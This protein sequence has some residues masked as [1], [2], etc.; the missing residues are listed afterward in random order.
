[1]GVLNV[2]PDSFFDGGRYLDAPVAVARGRELVAQGADL[3]DVGGESTRPGAAPVA[4]DEELARVIPVVETL[5]A[6]VRV[7]VDTSKPEVARAA[8]A[9]GASLINDVSATLAPIAAECG[10]GIVLMHMA[11]T[12]RT[13]QDH[14]HY[15]D[16]V[17]EVEAFLLARAASAHAAGVAEV[18]IDPGIGFGKT[19][20]H[21]LAL[22]AATRR[23]ASHGE[24]VLVGTSRK[25]FLG[26]LI[27]P[28]GAPPAGIDARFE[29]S[30]ATATFAMAEGAS[31]IRV[32][33]VR[34]CAQAAAL[35]GEAA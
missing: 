15:D 12:P 25:S 32:H 27:S 16:V 26:A 6:E 5:A 11:G 10:V 31:I 23:L 9:A 22:L 3:V 7:S 1:M 13:M 2:T 17:G 20:A 8:V 29:G 35:T 34:A 21:N 24:P 19:V 18:Y 4:A 28:P 14:P 30:L 33:D